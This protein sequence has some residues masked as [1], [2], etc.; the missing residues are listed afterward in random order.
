META[1]LYLALSGLLTVLLWTPYIVGRLFVWG[2]PTFLSNYPEGFPKTGR[3]EG[4]FMLMGGREGEW[5]AR[6]TRL[7]GLSQ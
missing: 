5:N 7:G 6:I 1:Y 4:L 3:P 2:I